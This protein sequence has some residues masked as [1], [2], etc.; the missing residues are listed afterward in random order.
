LIIAHRKNEF[1]IKNKNR[2]DRIRIGDEQDKKIQSKNLK[3]SFFN[4][5][6]LVH[7]LDLILYILSNSW[8]R[9]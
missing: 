8:W 4:L 2:M 1:K 3:L 7:L 5:L 9:H 6:H